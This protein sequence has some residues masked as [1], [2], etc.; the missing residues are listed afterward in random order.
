M[1]TLLTLCHF[2][3]QFNNASF[4]V[5]QGCGGMGLYEFPL[6]KEWEREKCHIKLDKRKTGNCQ[7]V[8]RIL[9][10]IGKGKAGFIGEL[11]M[12]MERIKCNLFGNIIA[13]ADVFNEF[14]T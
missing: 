5:C 2:H 6:S 11:R 1:V 8:S 3:W 9:I 13:G 12:K 10:W 14:L 7:Q 4:G